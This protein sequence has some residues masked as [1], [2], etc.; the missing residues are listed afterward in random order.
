LPGTGKNSVISR[1]TGRC[2]DVR[3]PAQRL[4]AARHAHERAPSLNRQS[5]R[6]Q[7]GCCRSG[8]HQRSTAEATD[9]RE[10]DYYGR[11]T[12]LSVHT[13]AHLDAGGPGSSQVVESS[14]VEGDLRSLLSTRRRETDLRLLVEC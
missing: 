13:E 7:T 2:G 4:G 9:H 6:A 10:G 11:T 3:Q 1:S 8:Q 12:D 14:H 5:V